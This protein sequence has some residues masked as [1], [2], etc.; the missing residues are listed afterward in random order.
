MRM[1]TYRPRLQ[2]PAQGEGQRPGGDDGEQLPADEV[3]IIEAGEDGGEQGEDV[4]EDMSEPEKQVVE[5]P[6]GNQ[7]QL[8]K[9][10]K[11]RRHRR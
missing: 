1:F 7:P 5:A 6:R 8:S 3:E 2:A 10:Q 11:R 9:S 4:E